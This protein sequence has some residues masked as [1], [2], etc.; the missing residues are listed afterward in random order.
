MFSHLATDIRDPNQDHIKV[1]IIQV[2]VTMLFTSVHPVSG[3]AKV[4]IRTAPLRNPL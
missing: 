2:E 4:D 3:N 1:R